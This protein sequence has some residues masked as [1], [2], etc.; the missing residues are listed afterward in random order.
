MRAFYEKV[1]ETFRSLKTVLVHPTTAMTFRITYSVIWNLILVF[2]I[3]GLLIV[4]L[5]MGVGVGY[6][7]SLVKDE[8]PRSYE[9][10]KRDIYNYEETSE[11]YFANNTYLGKLRT[12]LER[13]EVSID[14][15]SEYLKDA[16]I[17]TE[18]ENFL[19]HEGIVP[20][21]VFRALFQEV[22]NSSTQSGGSTLTQQLI[23][24]QILTNEVSFER[25][26]KE[27]L[28]ALRL[29]K[30]FDK[31]EILEAYLNVST[32]GRNSSGRNIAGV[33]A[34]AKG[35]FGVEAKDLNIPQAAFIAGLPQSPF[36]YTPFTREGKIK[37]E[38]YLQPG[39]SRQKVVLQR[40]YEAGAISKKEYEDALEYDIVKDFIPS[41]ANPLDK[42][43]YLT[44]R[45]EDRAKEIL[46]YVLAEKD[47]YSKEDLQNSKI[48]SDKYKTLAGR[49]LRR[50]G[51]KIYTTVN[52]KLY[53]EYQKVIKNFK[54]YA[55]SRKVKKE[56]PETKEEYMATEP[57]EV[58]VMLIEN[59][60]G[61]ILSFSGGRDFSREQTDHSQALRPIGSTAK[62][63]VVYGPGIDMGLI[64]PGTVVADVDLGIRIN[65]RAWPQNF[66]ERYYGLTSARTA[67]THSYNVS[68]VSFF[69]QILPRDPVKNYLEKM[70]IT[71]LRRDHYTAPSTAL[72]A[73]DISVEENTNAFATFGNYG[74]FVD[75]NL[76]E[77]IVD[78]NGN[79]IFEHKAEPVE[80]FSPQASYLTVDMMRDVVKKG[81][82]RSLANY[83][84]FSAD[85]A[86]KTGT[87]ND[88]RDI[89]FVGLNPNVTLGIWM[90]YDTPARIPNS[91]TLKHLQLWAEL[92]NATNKI[93]PEIVGAKDT[94]KMPGGIVKRE[95]C[96]V[97]G[98]LPSEACKKAGFAMSD[99]FIDKYVPTE[100]DNSIINGKYVII[101]NKKYLAM[102]STPDEFAY[103]GIM[104]NLDFIKQIAPATLKDID[105]L[106]PNTSQWA[107]VLVPDAKI[108]ENGK[109]PAPVQI[110][111]SGNTIQWNEHKENDII[112]Y[113]V[114]KIVNGNRE[115][116]AS[117]SSGTKLSYR[118]PSMG[119]Y[120]ITAVDIAGNESD[121]SNIVK[122]GLIIEIPQ[123]GDED[124]IIIELPRP[125]DSEE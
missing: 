53:E 55:P 77:K 105:Q 118:I 41:R 25:K 114:Y 40:M 46:S 94:F 45:V 83:L 18:D 14:Q 29:E 116:V 12:D 28:L 43:P 66:S 24:N 31:E 15:V 27:I 61:N 89:W 104:L 75:S 9:S 37:E 22:T 48:L 38:Q 57:I 19:D 23:K 13:E 108:D 56:D 72:G 7:A 88:A 82:A 121:L 120:A 59:K 73:P 1:I 70:G 125:R 52:K 91:Y 81:T 67:L 34:A 51:Y 5:G 124:E 96:G 68:A 76:V 74:N 102:A 103:E 86:G 2:L 98:L 92:M 63:L 20:K 93:V 36:R 42:Y 78:Q 62:P 117:I 99:Y 122:R 4:V 8:K 107:N 16:V 113:R 33:Q 17:A 84:N 3:I 111:L 32:F 71:S 6:F 44:F 110:K 54:A 119:Q 100:E 115:K 26:A 80:V 64:S 87:S 95:Y 35:I 49:D 85:F 30:F 50:N 69:N 79:V 65:G 106:I 60:T 97:S 11:V 21:A 109:V 47:G 90:G 10:M 123:D 101:K 112:G 58:G 39:L